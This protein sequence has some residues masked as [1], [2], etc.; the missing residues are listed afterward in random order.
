[1]TSHTRQLGFLAGLV[2][3]VGS[4][5][6][7]APASAGSTSTPKTAVNVTLT[8]KPGAIAPQ[9]VDHH[10]RRHH[11]RGR[12]YRHVHPHGY[13]YNYGYGYYHRPYR[14]ALPR[15]RR[16]HP[17]AYGYSYAPYGYYYAPR[18]HFRHAPRHR[19]W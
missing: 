8:A 18:R 17:Y 15:H 9:A 6:L 10:R 12:R 13:A 5:A 3:F 16:Y 7:A 4:F 14:R 19:R 1:M 2:F 11:H